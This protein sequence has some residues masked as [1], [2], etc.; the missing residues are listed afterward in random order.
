MILEYGYA[1]ASTNEDKQDIGRQ[2]RELVTMGIKENNIFWEYESGSHEDR[3]KLMQLLETVKTGD[4]IA[5][6]EVSR[7]SRSTKQLCEILEFVED[8][9]IKLVVGGFVV[10]CTGNE[11]DPMTMGMLRMMSVFSQ[12]EREIT[13]QRIKS[14]MVNAKAKGK[15]IGRRKTTTDD[16]PQSFFRYYPQFTN[17]NINLSEF[18]RL[19]DLSRNSIY[20][21]LKIV[22]NG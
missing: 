9:H 11:I 12:M 18:S 2:K 21:Y 8:N 15:V 20:K 1:R 13:I 4:T 6:T 16:I 7:L 3:E 17:R 5:C 22:E 14:G 19:S 10:D